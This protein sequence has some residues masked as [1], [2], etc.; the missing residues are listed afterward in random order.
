M[1]IDFSSVRWLEA[2][3][4]PFGMRVLDCRSVTTHLIASSQDQSVADRFLT[5]RRQ[6]PAE[7]AGSAPEDAVTLPCAL[8]YPDPAALPDGLD[9]RAQVMEDK[10]DIFQLGDTLLFL[11][12]WTGHQ[13]FQAHIMTSGDDLVVDSIRAAAGILTAEPDYTIAQVDFLI[14]THLY[15]RE[16][17]HPLPVELPEDVANLVLY[18]FSQYGRWAYYGSYENTAAL[19]IL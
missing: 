8:R 6:D 7:L 17:P 12:S 1:E 13:I 3:Q 4:N 2:G 5:L 9:Y 18:S 15:R 19:H 10:W 16:V 11:R 14:K